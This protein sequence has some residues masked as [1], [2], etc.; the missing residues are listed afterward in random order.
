[1][2]SPKVNRPSAESVSVHDKTH[3]LL[4]PEPRW[5]ISNHDC[6]YHG[7]LSKYVIIQR[8]PIPPVL[9]PPDYTWA[10]AWVL[11]EGP[12]QQINTPE[13]PRAQRT[14]YHPLIPCLPRCGPRILSDDA[15]GTL[16]VKRYPRIPTA[17][18]Q[19][20]SSWV[21]FLFK[22]KK[23]VLSTSYQSPDWDLHDQCHGSTPNTIPSLATPQ[24]PLE[25]IKHRTFNCPSSSPTSWLCAQARV[26]ICPNR[27]GRNAPRHPGLWSP[28]GP[29][30]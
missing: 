6:P 3:P 13:R 24:A 30:C 18:S 16:T 22:N 25:P 12:S 21:S 10:L 29:L 7:D 14:L 20:H 5:V 26:A 23:W 19:L 8:K 17:E 2:G 11:G 27:F 4:P 28:R 9:L 1:M 15:A